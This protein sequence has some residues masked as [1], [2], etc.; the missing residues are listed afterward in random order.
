MTQK[1]ITLFSILFLAFLGIQIQ[2]APIHS[3]LARNSKRDVI[4]TELD[5]EVTEEFQEDLTEEKKEP[6]GKDFGPNYTDRTNV[7]PMHRKIKHHAHMAASPIIWYELIMVFFL[8]MIEG[9]FVDTARKIPGC[10]THLTPIK[11]LST[12]SVHP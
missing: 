2:A 5:I 8:L 7:K 4:P 3:S 9:V 1:V 11:G 6:E 12:V 10:I